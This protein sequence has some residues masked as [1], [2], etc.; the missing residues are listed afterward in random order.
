MGREAN[1]QGRLLTNGG[2]SECSE[3]FQSAARQISSC[4]CIRFCDQ[5]PLN[6]V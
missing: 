6:S 2:D 1:K 5:T 4:H 3:F